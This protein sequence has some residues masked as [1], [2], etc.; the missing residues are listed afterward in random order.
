MEVV[1]LEKFG[2]ELFPGLF[3]ISERKEKALIFANQQAHHRK[4]K[5]KTTMAE[6]SC[7]T[8]ITPLLQ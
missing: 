6:E 2:Q 7:I 1:L 8:R 3:M 5:K 4:N